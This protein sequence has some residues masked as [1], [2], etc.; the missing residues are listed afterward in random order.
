MSK[1]RRLNISLYNHPISPKRQR[2]HSNLATIRTGLETESLA[3]IIL[4]FFMGCLHYCYGNP[5]FI[6]FWTTK[7]EEEEEE[8]HSK[9]PSPTAITCTTTCYILQHFMVLVFFLVSVVKH[10][11]TAQVSRKTKDITTNHHHHDH[12]SRAAPQQN[13][14][15]PDSQ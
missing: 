3:H 9:G 13:L 2:I 5:M 15:W 7:E 11:W 10:T 14:L 12:W 1:I 8:G 6:D 4:P